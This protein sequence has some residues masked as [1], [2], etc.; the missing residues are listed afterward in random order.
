MYDLLDGIR[1][2]EVAIAAPDGL[3]AHL[4]DMGAE[5]I[6]L[7]KPPVGDTTRIL[8]DPY[9]HLRWNR[10]KKSVALNLEAPE[11]LP[12]AMELVKT[13][14]VVIDG[15]RAGNMERFG[16][17]YEAVQVV[18][19]AVVYCSLSGMGQTG[20]YRR[21]GV[22]APAFDAYAGIAPVAYREDGLPYAAPHAAVGTQ[23]GPL[24]AAF[25]VTAALVKAQRTG[26]GQ[27]IDVAEIDAVALSRGMEIA[28]G[29]NNGWD[30]ARSP[31]QAKDAVRGQYYETSD[32]KYVAFQ[33]LEE[34][35]WR[36]FCRAVERPDLLA[37][38]SGRPTDLA[39]GDEALRAEL[40]AIMKTRTQAE[41]IEF[42]IAHDVPGGPVYT[43]QELADDP[44]FRA[45]GNVGQVE[46]P[47]LGKLLMPTTPIK[48]PDQTF[49]VRPAPELG[50][51]TDEVLAA[52][53]GIDP[54][55]LRDLRDRGVIQ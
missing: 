16:L 27:Y 21:L 46:D 45:R 44:H 50:Q 35:F 29:L 38:S 37:R 10:G 18:N 36:N 6:K 2:L 39:S 9:V 32:E 49:E 7:E 1:V 20:P 51:H 48:L 52:L 25:A 55:R 22:H 28:R 17:G 14:H 30:A 33:P 19:S 13:V 11:A 8:H 5:V 42:F 3:G 47:R 24:A 4:A 34:K 26:R 12:L 43:V 40:V 23:A 54:D 31:W 41:W 15:M 53:P